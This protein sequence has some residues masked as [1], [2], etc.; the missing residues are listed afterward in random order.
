M[1]TENF[2]PELGIEDSDTVNT[3]KFWKRTADQ[4]VKVFVFTLAVALAGPALASSAD[5]DFGGQLSVPWEGSLTAAVVATVGSLLGSLVGRRLG[6]NPADPT[7]M[8]TG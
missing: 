8:K 7:W 2:D 1:T 3:V 4:A 5:L 6:D